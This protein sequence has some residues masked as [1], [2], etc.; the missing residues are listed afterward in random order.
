[1]VE[2]DFKGRE[3]TLYGFRDGEA[4]CLRVVPTDLSPEPSAPAECVPRF[5]LDRL[6]QPLVALASNG[7]VASVGERCATA[8]YGVATDR[9][10]TV[11]V[12]RPSG[13]ATAAIGNNAF[14]SIADGPDCRSNAATSVTA[15]DAGG[16]KST[17]PIPRLHDHFLNRPREEELPGPSKVD[18]RLTDGAVGWLDRGELRG[19][20]FTWPA[21]TARSM[22][23][24][25]LLRPNPG[26][27]FRL[28]VGFK[29]GDANG[30]WYCLAHLWP[31]VKGPVSH[32]CSR[33]D[34]V[35][36]GIGLMGAW[37]NE[38]QFPLYVGLVADDVATLEL[39]YASGGRRSIPLVDNAFAFQAP[40]FENV[41]LVARDRDGLV[42]KILVL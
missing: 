28:G 29:P 17:M 27:S 37:P 5:E 24:S 38:S 35:R 11:S 22:V 25:R 34:W 16:T 7:V 12:E 39:Y 32:G 41:K 42:V 13:S 23:T 8:I 36:G 4:L 21:E 14:L 3:Y 33:A 6:D 1:L 18:R 15:I 31:L 40:F 30:D 10:E 9:V 20:P 19:E 26:I 2:S